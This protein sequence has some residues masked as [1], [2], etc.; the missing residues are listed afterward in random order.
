MNLK[1][2]NLRLHSHIPVAIKLKLSSRAMLMN[3]I[4]ADTLDSDSIT[5][6]S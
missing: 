1:M 4:F 5:V 2:I 6:T 3:M